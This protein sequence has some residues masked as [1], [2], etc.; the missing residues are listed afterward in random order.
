[1]QLTLQERSFLNRYQKATKPQPLYQAVSLAVNNDLFSPGISR[2]QV[3]FGQIGEASSVQ[4][5]PSV[6]KKLTPDLVHT[7]I[8][9]HYGRAYV[10]EPDI[11]MNK[12]LIDFILT[13][14]TING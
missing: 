8:L 1:M 11:I 9:A 14:K 6:W 2:S 4:V 10:L 13:E 3:K 5:D 12:E 7:Y